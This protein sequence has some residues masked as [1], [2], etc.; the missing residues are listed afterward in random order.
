NEG[1]VALGTAG[2]DLGRPYWLSQLAEVCIEI[3]RFDDGLSALVEALSFA[4]KNEDRNV[5]ADLY[6]LK[7]ELVL[8][9]GDSKT[10]EAQGCFQRAIDVARKQSAKSLELRATMSLVRLLAKQGRGAEG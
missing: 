7:G 4:E 5:E 1:L 2:T 9:Q 6:R 10:A 8:V 3:G